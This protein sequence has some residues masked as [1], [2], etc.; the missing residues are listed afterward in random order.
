MGVGVV[1]EAGEVVAARDMDAAHA[2][3]VRRE[4]LGIEGVD[5][6]AGEVLAEADE[7]DF[8]CRRT[9]AEHGFAA[10]DA[11][12]ADTVHAADEGIAV[13]EF[14]AVRA[15][16]AVEFGVAA[17]D[18]GGDPAV[19]VDVG[20]VVDNAAKGG[21]EGKVVRH[22]AQLFAQA[23]AH[24][25]AI[26]RDDAARVRTPPQD[27]V[28]AVIPGKNAFAVRRKDE[29]GVNTVA[30]GEQAVVVGALGVGEAVFCHGYASGRRRTH[31]IRARMMRASASFMWSLLSS[32]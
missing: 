13:P 23:A 22:G 6:E 31:S 28:A 17:V 2:D 15:A 3:E 18:V 30:V 5:A 20:A 32:R 10:E 4:E 8:R 27:G 25:H 21:I 29:S 12:Q 19:A 1:G 14:A 7:D 16:L 26:G 9:Q 11:F 24:V